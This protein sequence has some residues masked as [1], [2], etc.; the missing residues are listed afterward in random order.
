M[1]GIAASGFT[2]RPGERLQRTPVL[3]SVNVG[4]P[5]DVPWQGKTVQQACG[6]TRWPGG[7]WRGTRTSTVTAKATCRG[8]AASS[9]P[10]RFTRSSPTGFGNTSAG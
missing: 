2:G 10:C 7:E 3:L 4:M 1:T 5:K 6:N 9:G 8:M